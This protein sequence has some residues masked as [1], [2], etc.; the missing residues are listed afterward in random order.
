MNTLAEIETPHV[1]VVSPSILKTWL[2]IDGPAIPI[3]QIM[4]LSFFSIQHGASNLYPDGSYTVEVTV[5][6]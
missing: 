5:G 6:V 1:F 3:L 4:M 2:L